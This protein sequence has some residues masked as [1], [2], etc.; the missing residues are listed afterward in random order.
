MSTSASK[1]RL[2]ALAALRGSADLATLCGNL[3][4]PQRVFD[5]QTSMCGGRNRGR[6]PL[7]EVF[8][9][10]QVFT[11][12]TTKGGTMMSRITVRAHCAG[13]DQAT[14]Q[15]LLSGMLAASLNA[16][17]NAVDS[18]NSRTGYF[19]DGDDAIGDV[20]KS[21]FAWFQD[22]TLTVTHTYDRSTY[23]LT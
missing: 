8:V 14:A 23:E 18:V 21:P 5:G 17:R 9:E 4:T 1:L 16:I 13:R 22:A 7:L 10:S 19:T 15:D 12:E 20:S 3:T 2:E 11:K 6:L